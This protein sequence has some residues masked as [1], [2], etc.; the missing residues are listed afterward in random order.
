MMVL[1]PHV[2]VSMSDNIFVDT[3]ILVYSRD[4]GET[5]KQPIA[6]NI[7]KELWRTRKGRLSTQVCNEYYVT[8]TR[9]L[10]PG[11]SPEKAWQDVEALF[12]WEPQSINSGVLKKA[13]E[14]QLQYQLSWWDALIVS[15]AFYADCGTIFSEDLNHGQ[16]YFGILVKNPF[17]GHQ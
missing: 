14:C 4:A 7:L 15:G 12:A 6:L 1:I 3:N 17:A 11:L 8:V 13:R 10:K 2:R 5:E 16:I 9:K